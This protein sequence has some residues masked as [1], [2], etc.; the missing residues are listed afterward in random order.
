MPQGLPHNETYWNSKDV[1]SYARIYIESRTISSIHHLANVNKFAFHLM[2][3]VA[4]TTDHDMICVFEP[5]TVYRFRRTISSQWIVKRLDREKS[6]KHPTS[7][8]RKAICL[9]QTR[10][11]NENFFFFVSSLFH[12]ANERICLIFRISLRKSIRCPRKKKIVEN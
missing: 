8:R 9:R 10:I 5:F 11:G 12:Y 4:A 1:S 6:K 7:N 2:S 3:G